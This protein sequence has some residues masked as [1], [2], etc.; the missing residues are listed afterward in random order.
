M[1]SD[2]MLNE[3]PPCRQRLVFEPVHSV[4]VIVNVTELSECVLLVMEEV[5][6]NWEPLAT[7]E[8]ETG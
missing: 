5:H 1:V 8:E 7:R 3:V 4:A 6:E 2:E